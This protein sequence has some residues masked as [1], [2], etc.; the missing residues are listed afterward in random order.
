M[1]STPCQQAFNNG[2]AWRRS[3]RQAHPMPFSAYKIAE[4]AQNW[5]DYHTEL[6]NIGLCAGGDTSTCYALRHCVR[7][8]KSMWVKRLPECMVHDF[9]RN[10]V[11]VLYAL[12]GDGVPQPAI[13]ALEQMVRDQ[14]PRLISLGEQA[15]LEAKHDWQRLR[16]PLAS[17]QGC[18]VTAFVLEMQSVVALVLDQTSDCDDPLRRS[19]R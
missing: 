15:R 1:K 11:E 9:A 18:F 19:G 7:E 14:V 3:Q 8:D 4:T 6:R 13:D 12:K 17:G 5:A 10:V 16:K 2:Q